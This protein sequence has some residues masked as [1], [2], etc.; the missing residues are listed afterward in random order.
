MNDTSP[1]M[2]QKMRELIQLKTPIERLTMGWSMYETSKYLI[3]RGILE[4]NPNI[5]EVA[6]RQEVFLR[7]YREDFNPAEREKILNY[8]EKTAFQCSEN[9][10]QNKMP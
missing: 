9:F 1:E 5:S 7:F 10:R 4:E 6:L 3:I 2:A 8:I